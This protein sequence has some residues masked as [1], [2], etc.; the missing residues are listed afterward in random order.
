LN[1]L[2]KKIVVF[3]VVIVFFLVFTKC[4]GGGD[5]PAPNPTPNP[6]VTHVININGNQ[7]DADYQVWD[8]G[9]MLDAKTA[10]DN[11]D[12]KLDFTNKEKTTVVDS[13]TGFKEGFTK[14]KVVNQSIGT[15]KSYTATLNEI[16]TNKF[17]NL[18]VMLRD[19]NS[20]QTIKNFLGIHNQDTVAVDS[21]YTLKDLVAGNIENV[22][23]IPSDST[24]ITFPDTNKQFTIVEGENNPIV[25]VNG[26]EKTFSATYNLDVNDTNNN[27]LQNILAT[28]NGSSQTLPA[29]GVA[30]GVVVPLSADPLKPWL[31]QSKDINVTLQQTDSSYQFS[32]VSFTTTL[33]DGVNNDTKTITSKPFEWYANLIVNVDDDAGANL[34]GATLSANSKSATTNT[35]GQARLD[36]IISLPALSAEKFW[37]PG[38]TNLTYDL[39][40][41][42][43]NDFTAKTVSV[44]QGDNTYNE[45]LTKTPVNTE[46]GDVAILPQLN[47]IQKNNTTIKLVNTIVPDSTYTI[48]TDATSAQAIFYNIYV[49][50]SNNPTT[51]NVNITDNLPDGTFLETNSTIQ[52]YQDTNGEINGSKVVNLNPI[53][54]SQDLTTII[55][56]YNTLNPDSN[57]TVDLIQDSNGAVLDS[58]VTDGSGAATFSAVPGETAVHLKVS[59]AGSYT[60]TYGTYTTPLVDHVS[61]MTGTI[62][63]T[64]VPQFND[65]NGT[66]ITATDIQKY[67]PLEWNTEFLL[68]HLR[69]YFPADPNRQ[70]YVDETATV[71]TALGMSGAII[72]YDTPFAT[73]TA[74]Q[75]NNYDPY[76]ASRQV[77]DGLIGTNVTN[78]TGGITTTQ[79]KNLNNNIII[80]YAST[81]D[82]GGLDW[83]DTDHEIG[84]LLG[85]P[86]FAGN[87]SRNT[88][89]A[90][91]TTID[92][93]PQD[94]V[95]MPLWIREGVLHYDSTDGQGRLM[96]YSLPT[97]FE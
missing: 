97:K 25:D 83:S 30:S 23:F 59:E 18:N 70:L 55:R 46:N 7:K 49:A 6:D 79:G 24:W 64:S 14:F 37:K 34:P 27:T 15:L 94:S 68:G 1:T 88:D 17:G 21:V 57:V 53:P 22:K 10:G 90:T 39:S 48:S 78:Y 85:F 77:F 73:P 61:E 12:V 13:I 43:Y 96:N 35:A 42:G 86:S 2:V 33:V 20:N 41:T 56:E 50:N 84:N 36:S 4:G 87:T 8:G 54:N 65:R 40:K 32:P 31:A 52:V 93:S 47:G 72:A 95:I 16:A 9:Y 51:Y 76:P 75:I 67:K 38:S 58:Q 81:F 5:N 62:N 91:N 74:S 66:S 82:L 60:I 69:I 11:G 44:S 71:A 89:A 29:N 92:G 19:S 28:I 80:F 26:T 63:A 3:A 45:V